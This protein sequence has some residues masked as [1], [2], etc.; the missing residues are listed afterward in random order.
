MAISCVSAKAPRDKHGCVARF[1]TFWRKVV[2]AVNKP[3]Q[4]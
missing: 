2:P 4:R 3:L 1:V